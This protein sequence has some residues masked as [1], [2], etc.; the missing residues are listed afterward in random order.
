M[1]KAIY[2]VADIIIT[3]YRQQLVR[4]FC[5]LKVMF[6]KKVLKVPAVIMEIR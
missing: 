1:P 3:E 5:V 2:Q 4:G 6:G